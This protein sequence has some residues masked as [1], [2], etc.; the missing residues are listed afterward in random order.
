MLTIVGN[1]NGFHVSNVLSKGIK[2]NAND[3]ITDVFIPLAEW[4][5]N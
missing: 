1:P 3:Y 4:R 2:F 5:V